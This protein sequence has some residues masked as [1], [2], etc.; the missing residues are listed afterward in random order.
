ME[1]EAKN[2]KA[3]DLAVILPFFL[4]L[5]LLPL[6]TFC[7][8]KANF[9]EDEN[10]T[11]A[12]APVL[13][14]DT[15]KDRTFMDGLET[16]M[17]DHFVLRTRWVEAKGISQKLTGDRE[18]GGVYL[19]KDRFIQVQ[20]KTV[21][22]NLERNLMTVSDFAEIFSCRPVLMVVPDAASMLSEYLPPFAPAATHKEEYDLVKK[23]LSSVADL[24]DLYAAFSAVSAEERADYYYKTDHHWTVDGAYQAYTML[25]ESLGFT[26]YAV[27]EFERIS[28]ENPFYGTLYSKCL[29]KSGITADQ[30]AILEYKGET[31]FTVTDGEGKHLSDSPFFKENFDQKDQY[32]VNLGLNR[33]VT[34]IENAAAEGG[35]L[36]VF[37]DSYA[38]AVVPF[39]SLHY[40]KV[41]LIDPRYYRGEVQEIAPA[42]SFDAVLFLFGSD[43]L[44]HQN[45]ISK[46]I[47]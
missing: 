31:H 14:F 18:I 8:P 37:K 28:G 2:K 34:V 10:R 30:M 42:G 25:G 46:L 19:C 1:K 7:L 9:S 4:V 11:L 22:E 23:H 24:P 35:T 21:D 26:P 40:Q 15:W 41:I 27:G 47:F 45:Q 6:I 3:A 20:S 5:V 39:L 44:Y 32:L 29:I 33:N 16:Y 13:R 12:T 36:L 17:A 38:N 43:S